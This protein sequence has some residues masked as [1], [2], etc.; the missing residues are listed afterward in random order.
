MVLTDTARALQ[1]AHAPRWRTNAALALAN[2]V[3]RFLV[4]FF[5]RCPLYAICSFVDI[6]DP[7]KEMTEVISPASLAEV[8]MEG[9]FW[10]REGEDV[11]EVPE[12][13]VG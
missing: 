8:E 6:S 3:N 13:M 5:T 10:P 1:F 11:V 9:A 7:V 4:R 12:Y 2:G